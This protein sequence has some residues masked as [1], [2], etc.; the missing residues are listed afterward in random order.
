M[1]QKAGAVIPAAQKARPPR[2]PWSDPI[3]RIP[4]KVARVTETKRSTMRAFS[5]AESGA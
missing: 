3:S 1:P 4:L 2:A 5:S